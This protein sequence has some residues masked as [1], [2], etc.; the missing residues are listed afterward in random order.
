MD[1]VLIEKWNE[2]VGKR[3]IVYHLGDFAFANE[4]FIRTLIQKLNGQIFLIRGNHDRFSPRK[5]LEWGIKW[6]GDYKR[7]NIGRQKV[8]LSHY[9]MRVWDCKHHGS[10]ML[11]GHSHGC[12]EDDDKFGRT[13][14]VGVDSNNFYP[15]SYETIHS[16]LRNKGNFDYK[17]S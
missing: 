5:Y 16:R 13:M 4:K 14:D 15:Y 9:A 8:I 11:Y 6:V 1:S 17:C 10:Y 2:V 12:L 3:D 7:I